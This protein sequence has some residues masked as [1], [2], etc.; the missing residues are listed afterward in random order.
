M[1]R[2][3]FNLIE[4]LSSLLKRIESGRQQLKAGRAA[5]VNFRSAAKKRDE[6]TQ[7]FNDFLVRPVP[8]EEP[9]HSEAGR[10]LVRRRTELEKLNKEADDL[11][12]PYTKTLA[13]IT[14]FVSDLALLS[15]RLPLKP[16]W[17]PL[18]KAI[19][20]L[21]PQIGNPGA[22]TDPPTNL[23]LETLELRL[24]EMLE[25]AGDSRHAT[26]SKPAAT[27]PPPAATQNL[28]AA[29][30]ASAEGEGQAGTGP[31]VETGRGNDEGPAPG[32]RLDHG[33][34]AKEA[35]A[36]TGAQTIPTSDAAAASP[37]QPRIVSSKAPA[38]VVPSDDRTSDAVIAERATRRQAVVNP[39]LGQKRWKI[40][41]L[42]T[43]AGVGKATVYGYMDGTRSWISKENRKAI[44]QSLDLE[45]DKLPE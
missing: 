8:Q 26:T 9:A 39:I 27:R 29:E 13:F 31:V 5:S 32:A 35:R 30:A 16:E 15:E 12:D 18:G 37:D 40:G 6:A 14:P 3:T 4:A 2:P 1:A 20:A 33:T 7:R 24:W 28:M 19:R 22:W 17:S 38:A 43:A 23:S 25:L 44:C 21:L 36:M 42:A 41:R 11:W 45:L 10:E 34:D